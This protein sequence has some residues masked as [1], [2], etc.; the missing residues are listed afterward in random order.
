VIAAV[1]APEAAS[2]LQDLVQR[3]D[4]LRIEQVDM[5][6]GVSID[7]LAERL[8][9]EPIDLLLNNA[10]LYGGSWATDAARQT[11]DG[12]DYDLWHRIMGVNVIA[13]FRLAARLVS[14]LQAGTGKLA[15][16][17][18][19]DLGSIANN[20]HGQ[21]HAYRSSK[22]ALN[23]VTKG[24]SIDLESSGIKVVSLAPGWTRTE[25]GGEGAQW[26]TDESV[27]R[28]RQVLAGAATRVSGTFIDLN[29]QAVPW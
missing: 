14:N 6:S 24:L 16:M 3:F 12:M 15:V 27:R 13:P 23:M 21:S 25:L 2:E 17:M 11:V 22:A 20:Q 9:E 29:G 28:Q 8:G 4:A 5:A 18:S 26:D 19:S 10:G 1:R 7:A